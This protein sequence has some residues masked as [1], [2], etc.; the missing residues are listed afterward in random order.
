M[1]DSFFWK[2][3][4]ICPHLEASFNDDRRFFHS[5][6]RVKI[7][8][9]VNSNLHVGYVID[10]T[11]GID[12]FSAESGKSITAASLRRGMPFLTPSLTFLPL[13]PPTPIDLF[14]G[15]C[16]R[17]DISGY[18][19]WETAIP[20]Y[21]AVH[22]CVYTCILL[23]YSRDVAEPRSECMIILY[24]RKYIVRFPAKVALSSE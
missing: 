22:T 5:S 8:L 1:T 11:T 18:T 13:L 15:K 12:A 6:I 19:P 2:I 4:N 3:Y 10:T 20:S 23:P 9:E 7:S 16:R 17:F 21:V 14:N 24:N